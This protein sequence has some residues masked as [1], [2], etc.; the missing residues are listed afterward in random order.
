MSLLEWREYYSVGVDSVDHEHQELIHMINDMHEQMSQDAG[1]EEVENFLGEV[2]AL[3][4]SHFAL[5]EAEMRDHGYSRLR[6]HKADHERLLDEI[7]DIMD[8]VHERGFDP[9]D[10][11]RRLASWFGVHFQTHDAL[12]HGQFDR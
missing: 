2:H 12:L 7:R 1:M 11:G 4:S 6:E 9:D 3:I 5:E 8:E 10:L